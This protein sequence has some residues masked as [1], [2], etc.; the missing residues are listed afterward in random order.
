M[1]SLKR[2]IALGISAVTLLSFTGCGNTDMTFEEGNEQ[3]EIT[4]SWWGPDSRHAYTIAAVKAFEQEHPDIK[5]KLEYSEF[6]GFQK[7]TNVKMAA[8]TEAD[9]MQLNYAWVSGYSPDGTG[10][11]DLNEL[12][13]ILNLSNYTEEALSYGT[14][15]STDT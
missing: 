3:K 12:S 6:T 10:F 13:D 11:Y 1:K 8:H 5:V 7:K 14:V 2:F 15:P 9:V 4:F